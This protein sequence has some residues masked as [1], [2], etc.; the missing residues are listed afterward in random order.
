MSPDDLAYISVLVWKE[1][2][3]EKVSMFV[4]ATVEMKTRLV[5]LTTIAQAE[6]AATKYGTHVQCVCGDVVYLACVPAK[7]RDQVLMQ[8]WVAGV[9]WS[10][11]VVSKIVEGVGTIVQTIIIEYKPEHMQQFE[12][13]IFPVPWMLP[14]GCT[15]M[16]SFYVGS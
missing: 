7:N 1:N 4:L 12:E 16:L 10:L 5:E 2:E 8:A 3:P 14:S 11:F 15:N 13:K 6:Q 9:I